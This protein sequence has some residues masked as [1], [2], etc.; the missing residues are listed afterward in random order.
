MP[1][2]LTHKTA[3]PLS[4][5]GLPPE[6]E[7]NWDAS[8]LAEAGGSVGASSGVPVTKPIM[9]RS[10]SLVSSAMLSRSDAATAEI[11]SRV[12]CWTNRVSK[13]AESAETALA[14]P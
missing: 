12:S 6:A 4:P 1:C 11:G 2:G 13:P 3:E 14:E 8:S 9:P 10:R 7:A 5:D